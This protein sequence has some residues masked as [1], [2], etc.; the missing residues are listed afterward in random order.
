TAVAWGQTIRAVAPGCPEGGGNYFFAGSGAAWTGICI[1]VA[2]FAACALC[3][4]GPPALNT[5]HSNNR[6]E[7]DE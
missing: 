5:P 3:S 7:Q 6:I 1:V 2:G 4:P